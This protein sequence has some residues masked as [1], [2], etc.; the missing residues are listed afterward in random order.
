MS[1]WLRRAGRGLDRAGFE[2]VWSVAEGRRGRRW[3][4]TR[5]LD[6]RLVSSLLLETDPDGRFAHAEL[7]TG[8]GLLTLHP[9]GDGTL[10]G[11]TVSA[12]G[13]AHVA[14]LAWPPAAILLVEGSP[15][16]AA[17]AARSVGEGIGAGEAGA[18]PAGTADLALTVRVADVPVERLARS[19]WRLGNDDPIDV[20]DDG[21]PRLADS[22]AWPLEED[23]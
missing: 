20:D 21:L 22:S 8:R 23:G 5:S 18:W 1:T 11:N 15:I 3:R 19:R 17:A 9:E 10:H 14:G 13:V 6:G 2:I 7:G 4:E 16:A 12:D